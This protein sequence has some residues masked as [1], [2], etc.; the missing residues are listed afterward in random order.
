MRNLKRN[1]GIIMFSTLFSLSLFGCNNDKLPPEN[2]Q[3]TQI[4]HTN[5]KTFVT[6]ES[7]I[8]NPKLRSA[9]PPRDLQKFYYFNMLSRLA[10]EL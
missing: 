6:G 8:C 10:R 5:I 7:F 4:R 1:R 2:D 3:I 9:Q